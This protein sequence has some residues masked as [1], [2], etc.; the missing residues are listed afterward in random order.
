VPPGR[1]WP[2]FDEPGAEVIA[3]IKLAGERYGISPADI[4]YFTHG[5]TSPRRTGRNP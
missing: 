4:A 5:T 3:G 2:G 1:A